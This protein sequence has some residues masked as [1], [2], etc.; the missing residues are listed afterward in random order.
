M[1]SSFYSK[2]AYKNL[3]T[4]GRMT[5]PFIISSIIVTAL[6]YIMQSIASKDFNGF[7]GASAVKQVLSFGIVIMT[8]FIVIF[9]FYTYSF[10]TK[11]R[12]KEL[13]IYS[14]L[15]MTK[16]Q[17]AKIIAL[18]IIFI[19]FMSTTIGLVL[20]VAFDKLAYLFLIKLMDGEI[21]F[22]F[23]VSI[24]AIVITSIT[25]GSIYVLILLSSIFKVYRLNI[26]SLLKDASVGEKEPKSRWFLAIIGLI[27]IGYGYYISITIDSPLK[28]LTN[29]FYAVLSVI[30]GTYLIFIACSIFVLKIL[31]NNKN[32]YY[33][34]KH[35]ISVSSMLYRMKRNAV[36]LANICILATMILVTM[37]STT[38]LYVGKEQLSEKLFPRDIII[39]TLRPTEEEHNKLNSEFK[40]FLDEYNV[41]TSDSLSFLNYNMLVDKKGNDEV[42]IKDDIEFSSLDTSANVNIVT[43]EEYNKNFKKNLTLKEDE[44]LFKDNKQN[45]RETFTINN[46]KFK[47]KEIIKADENIAKGESDV[48]DSYYVVVKDIDVINKIYPKEKDTAIVRS[49]YMFNVKQ[50]D[51]SG[52]DLNKKIGE[53]VDKINN[54]ELLINDEKT[55]VFV[56]Y[57]SRE[58]GVKVIKGLFANFL[59]IGIFISLVFLISQIVIMYYKQ[60]SEG[61]DDKRSFAIMQK[62]GLEDREIKQSIKSQILM[63][64]FSPLVVALIHV[65]V[66]YPFIEK[67]LKLFELNNRELFLGTMLITFAIF[68]VFYGIVYVLTSRVYY[69]IIK[70]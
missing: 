34:T 22:G 7:Q 69:K 1:N 38:T 32:Y 64:F 5:F 13:G 15:G 65:I 29:F 33:K 54:R 42:K 24:K 51:I 55:E 14:V 28:A 20:G 8:I 50:S 26:I 9:M 49:T 43:L 37:G 21:N 70:E 56:L 41:E 19:S 68:V 46:N 48:T 11:K 62:V 44:I 23:D 45:S 39:E 66:S 10:I 31:K 30:I 61:Y 36:G 40:K 6:F 47:V 25:F 3:K 53:L 57:T 63:V 35:F 27:L 12:T 59:F 58:E 67:L 4:N 60:I 2:I 52:N 16:G 17:I 18:E